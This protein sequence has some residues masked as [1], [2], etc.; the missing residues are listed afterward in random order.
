MFLNTLFFSDQLLPFGLGV[1]ITTHSTPPFSNS[2]DY[3]TKKE[4]HT[5]TFP[6][7]KHPV[8]QTIV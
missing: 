4:Q 1:A 2:H 8:K 5:A 7:K 3:D 6:S